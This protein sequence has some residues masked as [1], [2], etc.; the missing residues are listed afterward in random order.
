MQPRMPENARIV[1]EKPSAGLFISEDFRKKNIYI[2][3]E[4]IVGDRN[5]PRSAGQS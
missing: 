1:D 4:D 2:E 3:V 5:Y